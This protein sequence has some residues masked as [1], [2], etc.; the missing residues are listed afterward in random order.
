MIYGE[1]FLNIKN[2]TS[3]Y[4]FNIQSLI[5]CDINN[6]DTLLFNISINEATKYNVI[7]ALVNKVRKILKRISA[8]ITKAV[9]FVYDKIILLMKKINEK[10]EDEES[11]NN[12]SAILNE[13]EIKN[14]DY[15]FSFKTPSPYMD[16]I[17]NRFKEYLDKTSIHLNTITDEYISMHNSHIVPS[18]TFNDISVFKND[19][20]DL[21][22]LFN[23]LYTQNKDNLFIIKEY[24]N[25][26][27]FSAIAEH[28]FE[29]CGSCNNKYKDFNKS[30][31]LLDKNVCKPLD[32]L[33]KHISL[34]SS[35]DNYSDFISATD[36][37][38]NL[39]MKYVA[40]CIRLITELSII[41]HDAIDY[42][43]KNYVNV[44]I[45]AGAPYNEIKRFK[46]SVNDFN[47][48]K[49]EFLVNRLDD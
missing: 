16:L 44:I 31:D 12:E 7:D 8:L 1:K 14:I 22:T 36:E 20:A 19:L 26:S 35:K 9:N 33:S 4:Q 32:K 38:T 10:I 25:T 29:S 42:N 45:K 49:S 3:S 17:N 5:E 28:A 13:F 43:C 39:S 24:N 21:E 27:A 34:L 41:T 47:N 23:E 2:E 48:G 40:L 6:I 18:K 46:Q 15:N 30:V 11:T 37:L